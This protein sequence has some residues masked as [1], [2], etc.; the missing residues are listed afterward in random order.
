MMATVPTP[1]LITMFL[2]VL[3]GV[4]T[5]IV[6]YGAGLASLVSFPAL[7]AAGLPPLTANLTNTVALIGTTVGGV[8]AARKE[9]VAVRRHLLPYGLIA[10]G[11]GI[12][13]AALLLAAPPEVFERVVPWLVLFGS[14]MLVLGP[15]LRRWHAGRIDYRHPAVTIALGAVAIYGGYFGAGAGVLVL[16][17]LSAV[18]EHTLAEL[19]A[20][21]SFILG[22]ANL[23]AALVFVVTGGVAWLYAVPLGV[24]SL[25]GAALGPWIMRRVP[26]TPARV[27]VALAGVAL[28]VKL[29]LDYY[30]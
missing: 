15:T 1:D 9:L 22:C 30:R 11:G 10:V 29:Y 24:G 14:I 7:L 28:A 13:G 16:A 20:L 19:T 5:G 27:V 18:L 3:A 23:V 4:L 17:V 8:S 21:R 6:G 2:L 12:A 25:L 26:E